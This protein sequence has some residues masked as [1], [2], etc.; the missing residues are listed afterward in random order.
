MVIGLTRGAKVA[1]PLMILGGVALLVLMPQ[2]A[3]ERVEETLETRGTGLMEEVEIEASARVRVAQWK[4]FPTLWIRAPFLG[5]G[6][7]SYGKLAAPY[8]PLG[9]ERGAHSTII[10][11]GVENG[12]VGLIA[13]VWIVLALGANVWRL[14]RN[15]EDPF[16]RSLASGCVAALVCLVLLDTTGTR[17]V[18]SAVMAYMWVLGGGLARL[19]CEQKATQAAADEAQGAAAP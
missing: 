8:D 5:N 7:K 14:S 18:S 13:Y 2:E 3:V 19:W 9:K 12:L 11:L 16:I 10:M 17:F 4:S 6:Y 15:S 1:I